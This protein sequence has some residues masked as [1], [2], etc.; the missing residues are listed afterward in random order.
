MGIYMYGQNKNLSVFFGKVV[1]SPII[2]GM[3]ND[4]SAQV[5]GPPVPSLGQADHV[6]YISG[7]HAIATYDAA[8]ETHDSGTMH[9][10]HVNIDVDSTNVDTGVEPVVTGSAARQE[11][12]I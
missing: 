11:S 12:E 8:G 7:D 4:P 5:T 10:N 3:N 2:E 1:K 9:S 6:H